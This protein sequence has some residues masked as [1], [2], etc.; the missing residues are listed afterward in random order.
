METLLLITGTYRL[1][2]LVKIAKSINKYYD[3]YSNKFNILWIISIDQNHAIGNIN[4][5]INYLQNTNIKYK[6]IYIN[7]NNDKTYGGDLF[8]TVLEDYVINSNVNPWV[9]ILDDDNLLHPSLFNTFNVCL[10]N[11]FYDNKEIILLTLKWDDTYIREINEDILGVRDKNNFLQGEHIIDPSAIIMKYSI[12]KKYG[13]FSNEYLYDFYW[14]NPL[15]QKEQKLNNII[16]YHYYSGYDKGYV[17]AYH[18]GIRDIDN[19]K[20]YNEDINNLIIDVHVSNMDV[21]KH[22]AYVPILSNNIK[23]KIYKLILEELQNE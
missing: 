7:V 21:T 4:N 6:I 2:N 22:S 19:I 9:Y 10:D 8:N 1:Y 18:N 16:Y 17:N 14:L 15:L 23:E 12:I 11:S 5:V 20:S 13:M 3:E